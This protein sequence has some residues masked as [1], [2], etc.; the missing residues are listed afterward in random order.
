ME[1]RLSSSETRSHVGLTIC[2]VIS[3]IDRST[4][5]SSGMAKAA[6]LRSRLPEHPVTGRS[7]LV[8]GFIVF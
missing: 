5:R 6:K 8:T 7:N 1:P 4:T 3:I 2:R